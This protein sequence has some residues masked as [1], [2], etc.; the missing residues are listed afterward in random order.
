MLFVFSGLLGIGG[1]GND[2][3]VSVIDIELFNEESDSACANGGLIS[4]NVCI[5]PIDLSVS[6][7]FL[8]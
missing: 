7:I 6:S 4:G 1:S 8:L 3:F 5:E 2:A